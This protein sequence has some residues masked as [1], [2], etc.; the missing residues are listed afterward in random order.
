M[1]CNVHV[2]LQRQRLS[3]LC[4]NGKL[5][6]C[7]AG[8]FLV[9]DFWVA[10]RCQLYGVELCKQVCK[11]ANEFI[12]D[13]RNWKRRNRCRRILEKAEARLLFFMRAD[14]QVQVA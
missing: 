14:C 9:G 6:E 10:E 7:L 11:Q 1:L 13:T 12:R 4:Y 2:R 5:E 8:L 3:A